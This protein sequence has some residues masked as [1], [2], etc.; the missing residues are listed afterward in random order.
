MLSELTLRSRLEVF[1]KIHIL[2][3]LHVE[4]GNFVPPEVD[5]DV[6]VLAGDV[7][8]KNQGLQWIFEQKFEAP[9][10]YLTFRA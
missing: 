6:V 8:V 3:D 10:L 5:A 9:V 4:F 7:H 2:S 1:L